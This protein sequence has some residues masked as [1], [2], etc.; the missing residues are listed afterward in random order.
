MANVLPPDEKKA[1]DTRV[2][3]RFILVAALML[4]LSA[5]ISVLAML[6]SFVTLHAANTALEESAQKIEKA[7]KDDKDIA[8]QAQVLSRALLPLASATTSPNEALA[9]ALSL[10]P[11]GISIVTITYLTG[12]QG[13][14][15]LSGDAVNREAVNQYRDALSNS[16]MFTRVFIPVGAL[17]GA[18]E[19][20][21]TITLNGAF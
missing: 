15:V 17:V 9:A 16:H 13:S 6:P 7:T 4:L 3:G 18:Q 20:R 5:S 19:G 14:L 11:A 2:R 8:T 1:A 21:V 12:A 10:K